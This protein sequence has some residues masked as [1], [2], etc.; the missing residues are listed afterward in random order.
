MR[1]IFLFIPI[2]F[3]L[4]SCSNS[5]TNKKMAGT[6]VLSS[7]NLGDYSDMMDHSKWNK[8]TVVKKIIFKGNMASMILS[9]HNQQTAFMGYHVDGKTIFF[10]DP[11]RGSIPFTIVDNNTISSSFQLYVGTYKKE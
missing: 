1:N 10:D 5:T 6:Y 8:I 3:I 7:G 4:I 11:K 2:L 9:L